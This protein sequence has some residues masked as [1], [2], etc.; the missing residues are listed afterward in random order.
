MEAFNE[1]D[2]MIHGSG[3]LLVGADNL[4]AW[5]KHTTKP[6]GVFGTTLQSPDEYHVGILKKASFIFTRETI[7]IDHLKKAGISGDHVAFAPDATFFLNIQDKEKADQF[8][9]ENG[10]EDRKFICAVP[11]LRYTPYHIYGSAKW[12]EEKIREVEETMPNIKSRIT[13]NC[14][15]P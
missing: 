1:A 6:F 11:R 9:K 12:S 2:I 13:P 14:A 10:L 3:P 7:S 4:A 15:R 8:L 5:M